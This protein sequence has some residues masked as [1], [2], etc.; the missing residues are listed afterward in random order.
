MK[1]HLNTLKT[2]KYQ[3]KMTTKKRQRILAA[4]KDMDEIDQRIDRQ[5]KELFKAL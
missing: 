3:E 2:M 5:F 4:L 1:K